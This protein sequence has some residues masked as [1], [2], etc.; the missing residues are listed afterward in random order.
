MTD[1]EGFDH[2]KLKCH[3]ALLLN[4][5]HY[6]PL[7]KTPPE[8]YDRLLFVLFKAYQNG[9]I[10]EFKDEPVMD[11]EVKQLDMFMQKAVSD[12]LTGEKDDSPK[13]TLFDNIPSETK[14]DES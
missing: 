4:Q 1:Q 12:Y 9:D 14:S 11:E 6:I 3:E 7:G 8:H 13:G 10:P 5:R 2:F